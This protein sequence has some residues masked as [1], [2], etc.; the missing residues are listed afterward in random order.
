MVAFR[1]ILATLDHF[2]AKRRKAE[3]LDDNM[4]VIDKTNKT[5]G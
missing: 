3:V 4:V 1:L 2:L 5:S